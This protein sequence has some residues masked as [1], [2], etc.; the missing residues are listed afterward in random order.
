MPRQLTYASLVPGKAD[1]RLHFPLNAVLVYCLNSTSCLIS[2][3]FLT[4]DLYA[5]SLS[6]VINAISYREYW[7]HY[8]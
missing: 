2:S 4:R 1:K 7:G 6:L 8:S 5:R 3:I